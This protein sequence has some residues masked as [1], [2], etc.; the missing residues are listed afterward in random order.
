MGNLFPKGRIRITP[1][2]S[3]PSVRQED[4]L[5]PEGRIITPPSQSLESFPRIHII[6]YGRAA[7]VPL[8]PPPPFPQ[9]EKA[10]RSLVVAGTIPPYTYNI[11]RKNRRSRSVA[12]A[13]IPPK[14]ELEKVRRVVYR[15]YGEWTILS[16]KGESHPLRCSRP[17]FP[18]GRPKLAPPKLSQSFPRIHIIL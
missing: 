3:V 12:V 5:F 6:L 14:G 9:R 7:A 16:P 11:V 4:N 15:R 8:P 10:N 18:E 1:S 17:H 13:P 2:G